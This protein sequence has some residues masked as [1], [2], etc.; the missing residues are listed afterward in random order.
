MAQGRG[1]IR[2]QDLTSRLWGVQNI[3]AGPCGVT[4]LPWTE[5]LA[6]AER[7][8]GREAHDAGLRVE[9]DGAGN[10]WAC[11]PG[12]GPWWG[13]GSHLDSVR[14]GGVYDGALGVA[15]AFEVARLSPRR[16]AVIAFADEEG[17]R[18]NTPTFGS[19]ALVGRLDAAVLDRRDGDGVRLGDAMRAFGAEPRLED[20]PAWLERL[21]GF[22]ELHIDQSREVAELGV[23]AAVVSGLAAR[24][25]I[26]V[27]FHGEA[28]HAGATPMDDRSDALAAA[29][30]LI[31]AVTE[32][33]G[34]G[35]RA[36]ATRIEV[37]P[38]ALSTIPSLARVW[39]D[40]R[41][42]DAA[43]IDAVAP[44]GTVESASAPVAFDP[45][46]R[47][48]LREA[49][50]HIAHPA[51]EVLSYAGHDAGILA[52]RIPA[53]MLFVR[54]ERGISHAPQEDVAISDAACGAQ[55]ML[56]ALEALSA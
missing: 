10:L 1:V 40:L 9:R 27:E 21:R 45:V 51:P 32:P 23:P 6:A 31:A 43:T 53:G 14:C 38:N 12:D 25:R 36:T 18:F 2:T 22:L 5:E 37:E 28:N 49:M 46:V 7:W 42:P 33:R 50:E 13:I 24:R 44:A 55:A 19:R 47:E 29:A 54:N 8:F 15:A 3:G 52:E 20:A 30:R 11:P 35:L 16:I 34:G 41:A 39:L 56:V 4:R 48:A 26:R 17:A